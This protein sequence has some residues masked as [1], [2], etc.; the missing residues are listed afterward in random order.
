MPPFPARESALLS[1]LHKKGRD[2]EDKRTWVIGG[3]DENKE[4]EAARFKNFRKGS[5]PASGGL[6]DLPSTSS[7]VTA[8]ASATVLA[9]RPASPPPRQLSLPDTVMGVNSSAVTEDI[10]DSLAGLDLSTPGAQTE[11]LLSPMSS[12]H[13]AAEPSYFPTS[14]Q[15]PSQLTH[16]TNITKWFDRL[17][18][19]GEGVLYEDA[20]IQIGVKSEFHGHLGRIQL[21][22]G[23]K[24]SVPLNSFTVVI[25]PSHASAAISAS[26]AQSTTSTIAPLTQ[27]Q[28]QVQLECKDFFT[29]P[30]VVKVS[31]LA[32]SLQSLVL[33]LPVT[34]TKF[35]EPVK[36]GQADF[37]ERWK[38]CTRSS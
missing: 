3:K 36:L 27:V 23:N 13:P 8:T 11:S 25:D 33:R 26:L 18:Y 30:P 35:I 9:A 37:F 15:P 1:R 14:S 2:T 21:Y 4:R 24:I 6:A 19:M 20:T 17:S 16:G 12:A 32:G 38:V 7:S 29:N 5:L 10:M 22:F 31:Y 34:L 28:Q